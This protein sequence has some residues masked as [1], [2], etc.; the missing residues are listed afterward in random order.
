MHCP[1]PTLEAEV[2]CPLPGSLHRPAI[3]CNAQEAGSIYLVCLFKR[4]SHLS[5]GFDQATMP[6]LSAPHPGL[7]LHTHTRVKGVVEL[8]AKAKPPERPVNSA[9]S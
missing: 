5:V 1:L 2:H 6:G 8:V 3:S 9:L 7:K 4:V